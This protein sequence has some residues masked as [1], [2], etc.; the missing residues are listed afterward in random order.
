MQGRSSRLIP[1]LRK[2]FATFA[3]AASS[4]AAAQAYPS[5]P[6][7][8]VVPYP[9]G[10]GTD[11][12]ARSLA[13]AMGKILNQTMVV[14]NKPGAATNIGAEYVARAKADGYVIM[15]ADTATLAANPFLYSNLPYSA[16]K[17]FA[18]IGLT[19]RFPLILVTNP[20]LPAKNLKDFLAWAKTQQ[21]ANYASPGPGAPHHL[22]T[23]LFREKAGLKLLTHVP[24][25]GA[26]PAVQD[27][28][29]GQVPFMF[30]DTAGGS[31][32]IAAGK[33]TAIGIAS[34]KRVKNFENIPTLNEQGLKG[35]EAF[36]WQG[37]V[38]PAGTP[39][40]VVATLNKALLAALDTTPIKARLQVLGLEAT[41]SS[42]AQMAT[43]ATA[44]RAKWG[45]LIKSAGIKL[46]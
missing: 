31:S 38:A 3:F 46:D 32:F 28:A 27:V 17:D 6:I 19:V 35:F 41:P 11:V 12:V 13:E 8:W 24:Y 30:V 14:N 18:P 37:L 10:G 2:V 39:A 33:L 21:A 25:K 20:N 45:P 22:A 23:E 44:E 34:S 16:E 43:Y 15:S 36:A 7:E 26:A 9:P 42:P 1:H 4:L 40:D 5:K 29:S